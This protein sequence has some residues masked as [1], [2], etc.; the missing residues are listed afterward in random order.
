MPLFGMHLSVAGGLH[1]AVAR[2]VELGCDGIQIFVRNPRAL[3]AKPLDPQ[4]VDSFR[5]AREAARLWPVVVHVNYLINVAS[6]SDE[7]YDVSCQ[8]LADELSRANAIGADYVVMHPGNHMKSGVDAAVVRI[9]AAIDRAVEESGIDVSAAPVEKSGH[10]ADAAAEADALG[11][12]GADAGTAADQPHSVILC[13]ENMV[14]AGTEVGVTF[15]E[16]G[17][18]IEASRYGDTLGICLDTCHALG[19]GYDVTTPEGLDATL[20]EMAEA[21]GISTLKFV[22]SND[23][24][25]VLGAKKD[26]H[27]N[28]GMGS[29]GL[30]GFRNILSRPE[31]SPL[32]FILE[33]PVNSPEDQVRDLAAIRECLP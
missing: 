17:R 3:R 5:A 29:I 26:R 6:P 25:G 15:A 9:A 32:P 2:A 11:G 12:T 8:A 22:H 27:Q 30:A 33:T 20:S 14:G 4:Q 1:N 10:T 23:S 19:W 21:V 18:I 16:L 7:T 13:L 24:Q 28:I 31:L